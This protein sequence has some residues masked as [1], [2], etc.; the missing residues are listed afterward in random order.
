MMPRIESPASSYLWYDDAVVALSKCVGVEYQDD[1]NAA[2]AATEALALL[3]S[4]GCVQ[5]HT[6]VHEL[7]LESRN[8]SAKCL[9]R[10]YLHVA[11]LPFGT[12]QILAA[13]GQWVWDCRIYRDPGP[14]T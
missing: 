10:S 2:T 11:T 8:A 7:L 6:V 9:V 4:Q 13:N 14:A 3:I 1:L 12:S 5:A